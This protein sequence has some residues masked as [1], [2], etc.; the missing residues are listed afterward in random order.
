MILGWSIWLSGLSCR[1][2]ATRRVS[3]CSTASHRR[4]SIDDGRSVTVV[5]VT[6]KIFPPTTFESDTTIKTALKAKRRMITASVQAIPDAQI[7]R[8]ELEAE[9]ADVLVDQHLVDSLELGAESTE[10]DIEQERVAERNPLY[11][12]LPGQPPRHRNINVFI[13]RVPLLS[14]SPDWLSHWPQGS[15]PPLSPAT[16]YDAKRRSITIRVRDDPRDDPTVTRARQFVLNE[17]SLLRRLVDATNTELAAWND[18]L[19]TL[20]RNA[21]GA[22]RT[23]RN[24]TELRQRTLG[25]PVVATSTAPVPYPLPRRRARPARFSADEMRDLG[26][27]SILPREDF[28]SVLS[29]L[30]RAAQFLA[31]HPR[32]RPVEEEDLR[33]LVL[34]VLNAAFPGGATG[35]TFS[36]KGKTDI[37]VVTTLADVAGT[38][39]CVFKAECKRWD[40]PASAVQAL[41]QLS[42]RYLT[43]SETRA[44]VILFVEPPRL[45]GT[46]SKA[47]IERLTEE[48]QCER[49]EEVAGWPVLRVTNPPGI[50]SVIDVAILTM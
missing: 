17:V 46:V 5:A 23:R 48:Y 28:A 39:D 47:A 40:G 16:G 18:E 32:L 30:Q 14:G 24:N 9:L 36:K 20:C 33:D 38:G 27:R 1:T 8:P 43:W 10:K 15:F 19:P 26:G 4:Q 42:E 35:E 41:R 7:L 11:Q 37:R 3:P 45:P 13:V 50:D 29:E 12:G 34:V 44:A 31:E 49:R 25:P 2:K 6:S 22:E 21:V